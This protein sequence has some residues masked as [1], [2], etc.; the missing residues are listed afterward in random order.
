[1]IRFFAVISFALCLQTRVVHSQPTLETGSRAPEIKL[2]TPQ[3]DTVAL[4]SLRGKLVLI[5]FW[6]SWCGPCVAEQPHLASLYATYKNAEFT[7]GNGFEIY[8][9]SFDSKKAAWLKQIE[10]N[11]ITWTQV[12]DLKFW[13]S[14]VAKIY[15]LEEI[16]CNLLI[17]SQGIILAKNLHGEDLAQALERYKKF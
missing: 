10:K 12:S 14:P 1:M 5:D 9:V 7:N 6:A 16:P 3:G 17:D 8:G 4:S 2:P 13:S 11:K 15:G